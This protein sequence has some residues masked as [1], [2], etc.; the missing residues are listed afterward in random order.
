MFDVS[1][2]IDK[3]LKTG[4]D[5]LPISKF[6]V[7]LHEIGNLK[8][9]GAHLFIIFSMKKSFKLFWINILVMLAFVVALPLL[10]LLYLDGYTR[11]GEKI[12]VP[13]ICGMQ[14]EEAADVLRKHNLDFDIVD[15]KYKKGA[16]VDEVLEQRPKALSN[17]KAGRK[18]MLTISSKN[19][20]TI[21]LPEVIDNCSL[22]EAEARLRA[23]GFKLTPYKE[24]PGEK[25]WVY[26]LL[27]GSDSLK[28]GASIAIGSTLTLVIGNG[29]DE[30][31][32]NE[33]IIDNSWFE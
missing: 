30:E 26:A 19:E 5:Y 21:A 2:C 28:N 7:S 31:S 6:G 23:A 1:C 9:A 24:V 15:H 14:I 27:H 20:P 4:S 12:P 11:H 3:Y 22:R 25:D 10:A 32:S 8:S 17:V 18:I 33:P 16:K 29:E 13:D